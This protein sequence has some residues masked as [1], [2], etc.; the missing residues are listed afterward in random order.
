MDLTVSETV[1]VMGAAAASHAADSI[2]SLARLYEFVPIVFAT[3]AS[4]LETLRALVKMSDVP[5]DKVI[6]FHMDEYVGISDRHPA[7]FRRYLREELV[8]RVPLHG[9]YYVEGDAADP[10][11]FC[12]QYAG[13][14]RE[15]DP[16]LCLAGIGENGHL[17]FNDPHEAD[18]N[19]ATDVKIE[20]GRAHV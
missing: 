9:F 4:Q 18:F 7:S 20:I 5:W 1:N 14:L 12:L 6:G 15:Y 19:D 3:G 13:L 2:R 17:A 16:Q 8:E 10:A 11:E